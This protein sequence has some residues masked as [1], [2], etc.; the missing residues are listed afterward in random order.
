VT[1]SQHNFLTIIQFALG[2]LPDQA[3]Q[4]VCS[5]SLVHCQCFGLAA[6]HDRLG[7]AYFVNPQVNGSL[8]DLS[9][10]LQVMS[11]DNKTRELMLSPGALFPL[12]LRKTGIKKSSS[13]LKEAQVKA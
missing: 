2:D 5:G 4:C 10:S 3:A 12:Q 6:G 7:F 8:F 11:K 13:I 1:A 9:L